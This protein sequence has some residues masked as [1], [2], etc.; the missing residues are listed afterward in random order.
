L[1]FVS[2]TGK[3]LSL[4][5]A[6]VVGLELMNNSMSSQEDTLKVKCKKGTD[7]ESYMILGGLYAQRETFEVI[8]KTQKKSLSAPEAKDVDASSSPEKAIVSCGSVAPDETLKK[9][10]IVFSNQLSNT[11]VQTF[12]EIVWSEKDKPFYKPWLEKE[13]FDVVMGDWQMEEVNGHWCG[14]RYRQSRDV[15]FKVKRKTHLYIGPPVANVLQVRRE[16]TW[17]TRRCGFERR[18][19]TF[20][21]P[22]T[23]KHYCRVEGNEKCVLAMRI[24]FEGIPYSDTL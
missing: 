8:Q 22:K 12:Y 16:G 14:E 4:K 21:F 11:S 6:E 13:C 5:W 18:R 3:Q 9:M 7:T 20:V 15:K 1:S 23:Q 17:R 10:N 19:L 2:W 24:E